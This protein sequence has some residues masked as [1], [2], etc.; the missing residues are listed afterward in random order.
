MRPP[1]STTAEL[2]RDCLAAVLVF[3]TVALGA[4]LW[5]DALQPLLH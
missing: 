1:P 2:R 4:W 5:V 3:A